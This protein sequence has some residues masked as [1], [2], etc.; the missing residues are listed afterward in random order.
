MTLRNRPAGRSSGCGG[1]GLMSSQGD[2]C[3]SYAYNGHY[4]W[5]ETQIE[6]SC[7]ELG[8]EVANILGYVGGGLY[9]API[10]I[11]KIEWGNKHCIEVVWSSDMSNWD[12]TDLTKLWVECARRMVRVSIEGCAP[13]RLKI[14]FHKRNQRTG[15]TWKSLP[16]VEELVA[17]VDAEWCRARFCL[18]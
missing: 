1:P 12:F 16:D 17:Q 15:E 6:Q 14:I 4:K 7:S 2:E 9:N 3:M 11:D 13:G 5:L 10:C 8:R 18:P